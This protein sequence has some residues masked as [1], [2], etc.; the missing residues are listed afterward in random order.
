MPTWICL[1]TCA[2]LG[3][4]FDPYRPLT[5]QLTYFVVG[6]AKPKFVTIWSFRR[7]WRPNGALVFAATRSWVSDAGCTRTARRRGR[8]YFGLRSAVSDLN[9]RV[10]V[11]HRQLKLQFRDTEDGFVSGDHP[12]PGCKVLCYP[13]PQPSFRL[14][15][16]EHRVSKKAR[17]L[18][19]LR[20]F[21]AEIDFST[22]R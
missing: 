16:R 15:L 2:D 14:V 1:A 18:E 21:V 7:A 12:R 17:N 22:R 13:L 5:C 11:R 9:T 19:I 6:I 10:D 3:M 20:S 8:C 4:D